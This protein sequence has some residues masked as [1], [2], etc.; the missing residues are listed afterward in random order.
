MAGMREGNRTPLGYVSKYT[1]KNSSMEF[2]N[3]EPDATSL[4][5]QVH[6]LYPVGGC[7]KIYS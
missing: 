3:L 6:I 1:Y 4:C 5:C 7:E 2:G